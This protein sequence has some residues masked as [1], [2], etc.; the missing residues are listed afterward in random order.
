MMRLNGRENKTV[1]IGL[2]GPSNV[3][4]QMSLHANW[5]GNCATMYF[6]FDFRFSESARG[7]SA[8]EYRCVCVC[9]WTM[10]NG[11]KSKSVPM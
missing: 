5:L 2:N 10:D 6:V 4:F 7:G 1:M 11:R 3:Q 9:V 8:I